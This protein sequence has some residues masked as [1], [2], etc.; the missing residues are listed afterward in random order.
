MSTLNYKRGYG[1]IDPYWYGLIQ[2]HDRKFIRCSAGLIM[3][4]L[5][6]AL[7]AVV[8][9]AELYRIS[10][11]DLWIIAVESGDWRHVRNS[12]AQYRRDLKFSQL[13]TDKEEARPLIRRMPDVYQGQNEIP[14]YTDLAPSYAM[15]EVG[16]LTTDEMFEEGRLHVDEDNIGRIDEDPARLALQGVVCW[17]RDYPMIYKPAES[18]PQSIG[19]ILGVEGL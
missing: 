15:T 17:M 8:V 10:P 13:I 9:V 11:V 19:K 7:G 6:R 3:P 14:I 2:G 18:S 16:R 1:D 4:I 12:L 5:D